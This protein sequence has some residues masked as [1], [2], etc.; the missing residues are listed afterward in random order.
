LRLPIE[1]RA[2]VVVPRTEKSETDSQIQRQPLRDLPIVLHV[3]FRELV[4]VV[5]SV[6]RAVLLKRSNL[7]SQ[8]IGKSIGRV[9][10]STATGTG[11][12][13][14]GGNLDRTAARSLDVERQSSLNV[15][16]IQTICRA[17]FILLCDGDQ[18]AE[19]QGV[20]AKSFRNVIAKGVRWIGLFVGSVSRIDAE[21]MGPVRRIG[22][23]KQQSG[24]L[25]SR[26][27]IKEISQGPQN[28]GRWRW[29][30]P[31]QLAVAAG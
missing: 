27:V 4:T 17:Q 30:R 1:G 7:R 24:D 20:F 14:S 9:Y 12:A 13:L 25:S 2:L 5:I 16:G 3:W 23:L 11:G 21:T 29:A 22:P 6:L 8:K 19:L 10:G 31:N 15:A 18:D 28:E 26:A